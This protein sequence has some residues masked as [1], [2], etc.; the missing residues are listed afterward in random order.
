[1]DPPSQK[2][3]LV[4][5]T[6]APQHIPIDVIIDILVWLPVNTLL[7]FKTVCKEWCNLINSP[8]F[9]QLHLH[10]SLEPN[11]RHSRALLF[12]STLCLVDNLYHPLKLTKLKWPSDTVRDRECWYYVGFCNGLFCYGFPAR[13]RSFG[14]VLDWKAKQFIICNPL[15]R[16]FKSI[17]PPTPKKKYS[18]WDKAILCGFGYD[19][20]HD[21]YKI[22]RTSRFYGKVDIYSLNDDLWRRISPTTT[23][24]TF[25]VSRKSQ[26]SLSRVVY[27]NN[28][29]HYLVSMVDDNGFRI[30]RFDLSSEKWIGDLNL[31]LQVKS[32]HEVLLGVLDGRIYVR[33]GKFSSPCRAS[34][35]WICRVEDSWSKVCHLGDVGKNIICY[36]PSKDGPPRLLL[37]D[38][39]DDIIWY[40]PKDDSR[41]PFQLKAS[42]KDYGLE[43]CIASLVK[44][45]R[46]CLSKMM[47]QIDE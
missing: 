24:T 44:I 27:A 21:D 31:P 47:Q 30:A 12:T 15:T 34:D 42:E 8:R 1:M 7:R 33:L 26:D 18:R 46:S 2:F 6:I 9:I 10:K 13:Y 20:E 14:S 4:F 43:L 22:V 25:I 28:M 17:L 39:G 16:T 41:E 37:G 5:P 19:S 3:R 29:L 11:S 36:D 23:T 38:F 32:T 35:I 45:P 40:D